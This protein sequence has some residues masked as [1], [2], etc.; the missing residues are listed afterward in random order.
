M[1]L[2]VKMSKIDQNIQQ[3]CDTFVYRYLVENRHFKTAELLKK[4]RKKDYALEVTKGEKISKIFSYLITKYGQRQL[5]LD[6]VTNGLVYDYLK[7]HQNQ[8]IQNR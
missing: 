5:E 8:K 2:C 1:D 4:E 6:S 3:V 7:N